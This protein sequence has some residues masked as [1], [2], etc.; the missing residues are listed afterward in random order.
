MSKNNSK[1]SRNNT[2]NQKNFKN[3]NYRKPNQ[4]NPKNNYSKVSNVFDFFNPKSNPAVAALHQNINFKGYTNLLR[5]YLIRNLHMKASLISDM[6]IDELFD[7]FFM[8]RMTY[9]DF[10]AISNLTKLNIKYLGLL[11]KHYVEW[12]TKK[13][14]GKP[15][16]IES[17]EFPGKIS[18]IISEK[19]D[20]VG[21]YMISLESLYN[22]SEAIHKQT[23]AKSHIN[24]PIKNS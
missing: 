21:S 2:R 3:N 16:V 7:L 15:I 12:E 22:V 9:G 24:K 13:G 18:K 17:E 11:Q 6:D 4:Q 8:E 1:N 5:T 20:Y 19:G 14:I 10:E 23:K